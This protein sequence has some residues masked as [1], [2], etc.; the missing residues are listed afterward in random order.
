M[1]K[2]VCKQTFH[3]LAHN[4]FIRKYSALKYTTVFWGDNWYLLLLVKMK[5]K[6]ACYAFNID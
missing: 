1:S 2:N 6:K 5:Q 4:G 3:E